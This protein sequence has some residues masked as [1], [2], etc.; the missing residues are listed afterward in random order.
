MNIGKQIIV[1]L[2]EVIKSQNAVISYLNATDYAL[3][4]TLAN[5]PALSNFV[6]SF[7]K[8]HEYSSTRPTGQLAEALAELQRKLDA[9]GA[10]LKQDIGGWDN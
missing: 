8:N 7:Q 2:Y 1:D 5:D 4:N 6:D 10:T 9:I 3:M